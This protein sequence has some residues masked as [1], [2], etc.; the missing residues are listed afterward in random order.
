MF[1]EFSLDDFN[2]NPFKMIGKDWMLVAAGDGG[3]ANAMT[4]S[5]GGLGVLWGENVAFVFIRPQRYTKEFVDAGDRFSLSFPGEEYRSAMTYLGKVSGRN[6]D[7]IAQCGMKLVFDSETGVPYFE[8]SHVVFILRK[9]YVQRMDPNSFL[10]K[11]IVGKCYSAGD[12]HEVYVCKIEKAL[13][14]A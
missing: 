8:E 13:R 5:W 11:D 2:A 10:C 14:C 1:E 9:L 4:A 12:F 7:K 6:E 3:K